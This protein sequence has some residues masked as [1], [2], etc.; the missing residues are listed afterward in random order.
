MP[1]RR[2]Y[3]VPHQAIWGRCVSNSGTNSSPV[4]L[5]AAYCR[6]NI[7]RHHFENWKTQPHCFKWHRMYRPL[8][9]LTSV[10]CL[11]QLE[12]FMIQCLKHKAKERPEKRRGNKVNEL[13]PPHLEQPGQRKNLQNE[14]RNIASTRVL[15][16]LV[17]FKRFFTLFIRRLFAV[18][19]NS[20]LHLK[21][22][23]SILFHSWKIAHWFPQLIA[24]I[25]NSRSA[26]VLPRRQESAHVDW[27]DFFQRSAHAAVKSAER[28]GL[29]RQ[30][31]S[32]RLTAN[33]LNRY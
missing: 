24:V 10:F 27:M 18:L 1:G 20:F 31:T 12:Y 19:N 23:S 13:R 17:Y 2:F 6:K 22:Y 15:V 33:V 5:L 29:E 4:A 14:K 30:R 7:V 3:I 8:S 11:V 25:Y 21:K 32:A 28:K 16:C 26:A 9:E